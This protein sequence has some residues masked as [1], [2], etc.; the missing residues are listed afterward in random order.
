MVLSE[1]L[2][3]GE[4]Y[5]RAHKVKS[6]LEKLLN[7]SAR[8]ARLNPISQVAAAKNLA[9]KVFDGMSNAHFEIKELMQKVCE[10]S[11]DNEQLRR[12][13]NRIPEQNSN[14]IINGNEGF[15]WRV[16]LLKP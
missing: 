4:S 12:Q 16:T 1:A 6:E 10:L 9:P 13:I 5:A 8:V 15:T 14:V 2:N 7:E 3:F 11:R